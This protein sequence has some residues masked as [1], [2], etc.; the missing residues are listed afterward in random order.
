LVLDPD[1]L[2]VDL[3][4]GMVSDLAVLEACEPAAGFCHSW[5]GL[6]LENSLP[7]VMVQKRTDQVVDP[8]SKMK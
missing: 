1:Y 5:D 8:F 7:V 6:I 3:K 4:L 2:V